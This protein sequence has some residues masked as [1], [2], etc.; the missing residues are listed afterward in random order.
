MHGARHAHVALGSHAPNPS[1]VRPSHRPGRAAPAGQAG[2]DHAPGA[3]SPDHAVPAARRTDTVR[4]LP[5]TA[6]ANASRTLA[7]ATKTVSGALATL[8]GSPSVGQAGGPVSA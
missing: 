2:G 1:H 7:P 5:G 8:P 6:S 4:S 3:G